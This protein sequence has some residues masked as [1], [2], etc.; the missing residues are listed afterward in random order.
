MSTVPDFSAQAA[1]FL[2][3]ID[4]GQ[5]GNPSRLE[6]LTMFGQHM[7][8]EG[9]RASKARMAGCEELL[10]ELEDEAE[11]Q[12]R[13]ELAPIPDS[14]RAASGAAVG[15]DGSSNGSGS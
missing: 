8:A 11:R 4:A 10:D 9:V 14:T 6:V 15:R 3:D 1:E 2:E 5:L 12:G 13:D 7:F